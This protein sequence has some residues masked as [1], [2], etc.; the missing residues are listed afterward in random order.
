[1][2]HHTKLT[3]AQFRF[4][5]DLMTL[6]VAAN[7]WTLPTHLMDAPGS[8]SGK[9][10]LYKGLVRWVTMPDGQP[11]QGWE[12][13]DQGLEAYRKRIDEEAEAVPAAVLSTPAV[14][15]KS[16]AEIAGLAVASEG[17]QDLGND[18]TATTFMFT[19]GTKARVHSCGFIECTSRSKQSRMSGRDHNVM[20]LFL[21]IR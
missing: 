18:L 8:Q 19:N 16:A 10:L 20:I 9:A 4:L 17:T 1:M 13:T 14:L 7:A 21:L 11:V 3:P 5:D 12:F 2:I 6:K 15:F